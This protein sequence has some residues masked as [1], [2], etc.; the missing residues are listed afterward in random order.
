MTDAAARVV[1]RVARESYGRLLAIVAA[2]TDGDVAAAE[3]ALGDALAKALAHWPASGIPA[4]PE[5]WLV[6]TARRRLLDA[7]RHD[8]VHTA[9]ADDERRAATLALPAHEDDMRTAFHDERLGLMF[10][11]THPA[12]DASIRTPLMLQV[13]LGLDA[14]RIARAFLATPSAIAQRLVR[15]KR[16][17][18]DARIPLAVPEPEERPARL[19]HVLDAIY[20][21]YTTGWDRVHEDDGLADEALWLARALAS[22]CPSE[23]EPRGLLALLLFVD[24][25]RGARRDDDGEFVPLAEQ[26]PAR[27]DGERIAEA[28]RVLRDALGTGPLGRYQLEAAIQSAHAARQWMGETDWP[29]IARLYDALLAC[30][31]SPVVAI[32]RALAIAESDGMYEGLAALDA[33]DADDER[34][35]RYQP[36]WAARAELLARARHAGADE[37]YARAIALCDDAAARRFL[38]RRRA[39]GRRA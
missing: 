24:A 31:P 6:T 11:C 30:A 33:V 26:D 16:K 12:L 9:W 19:A 29:A 34:V 5:A 35:A 39:A 23:A 10:A 37:A 17:I 1:E 13:V 20:S 28:E 3:D 4:S 18:R 8:D 32:N 36:Y 15:A 21:A 22:L 7:R 38:E 2:R 25:R 27:W 14:A